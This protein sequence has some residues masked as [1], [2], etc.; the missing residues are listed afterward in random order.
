MDNIT[1]R[2]IYGAYLTSHAIE[3]NMRYHRDKER[4]RGAAAR[5]RTPAVRNVFVQH[6]AF[7]SVHKVGLI[8]GLQESP[9]NNLVFE[10]VTV[11]LHE[12][13]QAAENK[14]SDFSENVK[15]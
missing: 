9:I 15:E 10:N 7:R 11:T 6:C 8:V 2:R 3:I 5:R 1:F 14:W 4:A 12:N 13:Q